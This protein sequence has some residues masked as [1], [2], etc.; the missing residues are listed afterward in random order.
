[1]LIAH[2]CRSEDIN[3]DITTNEIMVSCFLADY[4]DTTL[5]KEV[6]VGYSINNYFPRLIN[7]FGHC[8]NY[9]TDTLPTI[10]SVTRKEDYK[11]YYKFPTGIPVTEND[12]K[13][14]VRG[15]LI[16]NDTLIRY[17]APLVL[18][19]PIKYAN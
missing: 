12:T 13:L 8:W 16:F 6:W 1:M 10:N 2:S 17:S 3:P 15:F 14:I 19:N 9:N 4:K 11:G 7:F 5:T 18:I